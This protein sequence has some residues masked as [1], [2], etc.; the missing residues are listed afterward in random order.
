MR[1]A[2]SIGKDAVY[3]ACRFVGRRPRPLRAIL[4]YHEVGGPG[5]PTES[6][7]ARQMDWL[8]AHSR[9]LRV[10]DLAD[11]ISGIEPVTAVTVDDGYERTATLVAP[12]LA[13]RGIPATFFLPSGFLGSRFGTSYG[14]RPIIDEPAVKELAS[15][16]NEIG[17]HSVTHP[18]LTSIPR[19]EA[20]REIVRSKE[21]LEEI[22][23]QQVVSFAYPKG[24]QDVEVRR[25]VMDAGFRLA[26]GVREALLSGSIDPFDLP[27]V[28]VGASVGMVQFTAKLSGGLELYERL[29]GR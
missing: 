5:G 21:D 17:A 6:E 7:F 9:V 13:D 12:I 20:Q 11:A 25:M 3:T 18:R 28:A 23:G 19:E 27:R 10:R 29:R 26:V 2:R 16:G 14:E 8:A 4:M 24:D 1:S 15:A 22:I